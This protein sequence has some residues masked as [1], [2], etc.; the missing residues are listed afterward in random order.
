MRWLWT[1]SSTLTLFALGREP[2]VL[3]KLVRINDPQLV[4]DHVEVLGIEPMPGQNV[5]RWRQVGVN[6]ECYA[7]FLVLEQQA[8]ADGVR[9]KLFP[10]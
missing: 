8:G 5:A 3:P 6:I 4:I 2:E 1:S 9:S 10:Y 7:S